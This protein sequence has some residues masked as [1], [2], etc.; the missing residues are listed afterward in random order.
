MHVNLYS[1]ATPPTNPK[2]N[3]V[4]KIFNGRKFAKKHMLTS[5]ITKGGCEGETRHG[6]LAGAKELLGW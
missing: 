3:G 6:Y 2:N 1:V 4:Q 5:E